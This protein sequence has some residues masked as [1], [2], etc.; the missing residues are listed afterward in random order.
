MIFSH[1][2]YQLSY[3]G[4]RARNEA[5]SGR[6]IGVGARSV[7]RCRRPLKCGC[8]SSAGAGLLKLNSALARAPKRNQKLE[9]D[10]V[11]PQYR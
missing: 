7:Q 4:I 9:L 2:L 1:V 11:S 3:L 10:V 5:Q 6:F 8:R